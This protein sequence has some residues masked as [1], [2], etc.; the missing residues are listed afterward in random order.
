MKRSGF[1]DCCIFVALFIIAISMVI[2]LKLQIEINRHIAIATVTEAAD[3]STD[4]FSARNN[5]TLEINDT[6]SIPETTDIQRVVKTKAAGAAA[7]SKARS[8]ARSAESTKKATVNTTADTTVTVTEID[9]VLVVNK[10]SKKIH[11]STCSY[12]KN[13]KEENKAVI[14]SDELQ[15]YLDKG[16][17]V[18]AANAIRGDKMSDK[19]NIDNRKIIAVMCVALAFLSV[20]IMLRQVKIYKGINESNASDNSDVS[21][22]W[23]DGGE[24]VSITATDAPNVTVQADMYVLNISSK[25]IHK[26][27]CQYAK[28]MDD[29]N[30]QV[31]FCDNIDE[32]YLKGYTSCSKCLA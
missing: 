12:A 8:K 14:S 1:Y 26:P 4:S 6:A 25:K 31:I 5:V 17:S 30:K 22:S 28:N 29:K 10:N 23:V 3:S 27:D 21:V 24:A 20:F 16:Y 15:A 9:T 13:M 19:K 11:S 18:L 7:Q 32:Y 2:T